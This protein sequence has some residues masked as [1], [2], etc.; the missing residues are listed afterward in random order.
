MQP[1]QEHQ[2]R[3]TRAKPRLQVTILVQQFFGGLRKYNL[4]GEAEFES[5]F[6]NMEHHVELELEPQY[7]DFYNSPTNLGKSGSLL[8]KSTFNSLLEI[9]CTF[10]NR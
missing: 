3:D 7:R 1:T 6:T 2:F 4:R 8:F 10:W 9:S 5:R